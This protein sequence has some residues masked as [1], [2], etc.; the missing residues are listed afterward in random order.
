MPAG[1][2]G[3]V[4]A[5][6]HHLASSKASETL[7]SHSSSFGIY[8]F[9]GKSGNLRLAPASHQ[10]KRAVTPADDRASQV[11]CLKPGRGRFHR[12]RDP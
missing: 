6:A 12:R 1:M 10:G 9:L 3:Q 7:G 8:E 4:A 2:N 5:L 11:A